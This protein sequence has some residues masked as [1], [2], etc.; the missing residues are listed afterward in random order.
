[1]YLCVYNYTN[2]QFIFCSIGKE[3]KLHIV[4]LLR[5][6]EPLGITLVSYTSQGKLV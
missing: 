4:E 2:A 6:T 3:H 5:G 1:M